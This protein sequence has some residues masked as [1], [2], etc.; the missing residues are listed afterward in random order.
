MSR[1]SLLYLGVYDA[2]LIRKMNARASATGPATRVRASP[3]A[4]SRRNA[5]STGAK[6][7]DT[8]AG[9]SCEA[10]QASASVATAKM[11]RVHSAVASRVRLDARVNSPAKP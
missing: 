6:Y 5:A 9:V 7:R 11:I 3:H 2:T 8:H 1:M 4:A 10:D